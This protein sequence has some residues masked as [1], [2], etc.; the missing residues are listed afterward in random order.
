MEK[1]IHALVMEIRGRKRARTKQELTK[2]LPTPEVG[3]VAATVENGETQF[4]PEATP[5]V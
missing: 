3:S 5:E 2:V 4:G 1:R